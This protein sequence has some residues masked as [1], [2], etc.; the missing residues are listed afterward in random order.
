M[1]FT[2]FLTILLFHSFVL[3]QSLAPVKE[4]VIDL[5]VIHETLGR[6]VKKVILEL[7][8]ETSQEFK[9]KF[10]YRYQFVSHELESVTLTPNG[11]G[12]YSTR[13]RVEDYTGKQIL[14]FDISESTVVKGEKL[15]VLLEISKPNQNIHGI[16]VDVKLL[17]NESNVLDGGKK[18]LGLLGRSYTIKE[19]CSE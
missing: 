15:I 12:G 3:A 13:R 19:S 10:N 11:I 14:R 7:D 2:I 5:G 8:E 4:N 17:N 6:S 1:K 9:V 16:K 18:L